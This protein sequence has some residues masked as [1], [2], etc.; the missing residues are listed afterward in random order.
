M[1]VSGPYH[2]VKSGIWCQAWSIV[3]T[4]LELVHVIVGTIAVDLAFVSRL[5]LMY[6]TWRGF[7]ASDAF[8]SHAP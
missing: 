1:Q 4:T 2:N 8:S 3:C 7:F 5:V 6:M